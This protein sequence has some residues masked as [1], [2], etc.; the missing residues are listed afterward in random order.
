MKQI[1]LAGPMEMAKDS[2][3][4]WR[5]KLKPE[6]EK[7]GYKVIDPS[8][9]ENAPEVCKT[10]HECKEQGRW[11]EFVEIVDKI[12]QRDKKSVM[13]SDLIIARW[14]TEIK[15]YGTS[16][17]IRWSLDKGIPIYTVLYGKVTNESS[18]MMCKLRK[19]RIFDSFTKL[20]EELKK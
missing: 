4:N 6:L 8:E 3:E 12:I 19:T 2:G 5:K 11:D 18:W 10:L 17:E 9:A 1:Y 15:S 14:D 13:T 7:L 20:L 16:D